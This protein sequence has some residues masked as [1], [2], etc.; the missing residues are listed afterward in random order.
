[1]IYIMVTKRENPELFIA[2][3]KDRGEALRL[4]D[5]NE[6]ELLIALATDNEILAMLTN[7][8]SFAKYHLGL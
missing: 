7:P 3:C 5:K 8:I 1:M 6:N 2:K 4:A